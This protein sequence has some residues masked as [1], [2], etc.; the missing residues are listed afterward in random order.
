MLLTF[1]V[2]AVKEIHFCLK[3]HLTCWEVL[4]SRRGS[5]WVKAIWSLIL[6]DTKQLQMVFLALRLYF[7]RELLLKRLCFPWRKHEWGNPCFLTKSC[8]LWHLNLQRAT[9][10]I[11][12]SIN[13][14][15]HDWLIAWYDLSSLSTNL[16]STCCPPVT[17]GHKQHIDYLSVTVFCH[18]WAACT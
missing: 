14:M 16:V 2:Q 8:F 1:I 15:L 12:Y 3:L 4:F 13:S 17:K 11:R 18:R 6:C 10:F 7:F 9:R 5:I